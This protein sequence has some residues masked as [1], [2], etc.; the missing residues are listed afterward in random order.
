MSKHS[1]RQTYQFNECS[2]PPK[3]NPAQVNEV[4]DLPADQESPILTHIGDQ[5]SAREGTGNLETALNEPVR[6]DPKE[7]SEREDPTSVQTER[8]RRIRVA[9]DAERRRADLKAYVRGDVESLTIMRAA[10]ASKI[11]DRFVR[12][13][14]G[15]LQYVDKG[16]KVD[17]VGE[18][19]PQLRLVIPATMIDE[20]LQ[21]CHDLIEGLVKG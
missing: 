8:I 14:D 13:E 5:T 12:D 15:L 20:V 6:A 4:D 17:E 9:Q 16:R 7:A 21:S 18:H 3:M 10:N 19:E 11:V 2:Q 1:P